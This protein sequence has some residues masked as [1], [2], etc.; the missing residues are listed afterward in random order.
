VQPRDVSNI[1]RHIVQV[2]LRDLA[3]LPAPIPWRVPLEDSG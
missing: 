2:M 3:A 1:L